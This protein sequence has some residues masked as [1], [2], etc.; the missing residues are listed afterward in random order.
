MEFS[1]IDPAGTG[2]PA[3]HKT[4]RG[5][6]SGSSTDTAE[7]PIGLHDRARVLTATRRLEE[8]GRRTSTPASARSQIRTAQSPLHSRW[9][10]RWL[11]LPSRWDTGGL[12][13]CRLPRSLENQRGGGGGWGALWVV[14]IPERTWRRRRVVSN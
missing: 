12:A 8:G 2:R 6:P 11:F 14:S 13:N 9:R 4:R 3:I 7:D 1:G 5:R 10:P